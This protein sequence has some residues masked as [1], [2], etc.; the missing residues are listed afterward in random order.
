MHGMMVAE[1]SSTMRISNTIATPARLAVLFVCVTVMLLA[2]IGWLGWRLLAQE[3]ALDEQRLRDQLE[4]TAALAARQLDRALFDWET[5]LPA[6]ADGQDVSLPEH[7]VAIVFGDDG[8][9]KRWGVNLP[10]YP[11]VRPP[12][13]VS[14]TFFSDAEALEFGRSDVAGAEQ[15]Y[16]RLTRASDETVRAAA[17]MRLAR[18]LRHQKRTREAIG[19]Y[20]EMAAIGSTVWVAGVP[21]ELV[22]R[23][24]RVVLFESIGET[25]RASEEAGMLA[26]ALRSDRWAIDR[27]TFDFYRGTVAAPASSTTALSLARGLE[28]IWPDLRREESGRAPIAVDGLSLVALWRSTPAGSAA[29][30]GRVESVAPVLSRLDLPGF[31]VTLENESR[32]TIWGN[33]RRAGGRSALRTPRESNLPWTLRV[34]ATERADADRLIRSRRLL[35]ITGFGLMALVVVTAGLVTF[36]AVSRE[37]SVARLQS[38]FVATVSHE[39]RTPLTAMSHLAE[40]LD[41]G[42]ASP[43]RAP[44]YYRAL[45]KETRRLQALVESLLDFGRMEAGRRTYRLE[46]SHVDELARE[47]ID[48]FSDTSAAGRIHFEPSGGSDADA[49]VHVDRQAIRLALRNL[50]DNALKYSLEP[51]PIYLSVRC[52]AAAVRISVADEG[53]GI[54]ASE[55]K[56]IFRKFVRGSTAASSRVSGTGIGLAIADQI[57]QAHG[58]RLELQSEPGRGSCFTILFPLHAPEPRLPAEI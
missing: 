32:Q 20:D 37:L 42:A 39:F 9:L 43:A 24:E 47:A 27:A 51:A 15:I 30:L 8:V 19:I 4:N 10:Y 23:R 44:Q 50:M 46:P 31:N 7:T 28:A 29:L 38:D 54:P 58:G 5:Q 49:T 14:K 45:V 12:V 17:L 25:G 33:V 1:S 52:D 22:A 55:Q 26:D 2:V 35:Q 21:A 53:P 56:E 36:R 13:D 16:R 6:L 3:R 34:T 18:T 41:E 57:V 11:Q 40:M 48:E